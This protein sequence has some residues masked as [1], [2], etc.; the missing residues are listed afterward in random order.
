MHCSHM[1]IKNFIKERQKNT[2]FSPVSAALQ[3]LSGA[4]LHALLD[5]QHQ[6]NE[7][8]DLDHPALLPADLD[9][10]QQVVLCLTFAAANSQRLADV[11]N[12]LLAGQLRHACPVKRSEALRVASL[13]LLV[14]EQR[15]TR[16]VWSLT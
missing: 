11:L 16:V 8:V 13:Y 15:G 5:A 4:L 2:S 10:V 1:S 14:S 3:F 12:V 6:V 9:L 7:P